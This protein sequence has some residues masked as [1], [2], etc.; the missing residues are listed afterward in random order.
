MNL[1]KT[2]EEQLESNLRLQKF[3]HVLM[4]IY[5]DF[6][7]LKAMQPE[8]RLTYI[9]QLCGGDMILYFMVGC[10]LYRMGGNHAPE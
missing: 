6:D 3:L 9:E 8:E 2:P 7:K 5:T 10:E 1:Y 4:Q